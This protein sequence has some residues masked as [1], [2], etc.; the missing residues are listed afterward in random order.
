MFSITKALQH[1]W[2]ISNDELKLI[3]TKGNTSLKFGDVLT[4]KS[5]AVVGAH[6][7]P[8]KGNSSKK[9]E[10]YDVADAATKAKQMKLDINWQLPSTYHKDCLRKAAW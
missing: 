4:T 3:L 7:L 9:R 6:F 2:K 5:G 8:R 1:G 10:S